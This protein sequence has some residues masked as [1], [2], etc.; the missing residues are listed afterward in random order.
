M[1]YYIATILKIINN[2]K[3]TQQT[4]YQKYVLQLAPHNFKIIINIINSL[5]MITN[6]KAIIFSKLLLIKLDCQTG[7]TT[8]TSVVTDFFPV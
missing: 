5:F 4:S 8:K 6:I 1:E 7:V 3:G 2:L